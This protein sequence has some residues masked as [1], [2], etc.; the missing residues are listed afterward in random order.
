MLEVFALLKVTK[1][2]DL[3]EDQKQ[4]ILRDETCLFE[5]EVS[6]DNSQWRYRKH[7]WHLIS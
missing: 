2:R 3:M 4:L 1:S 7:L 6:A 5:V